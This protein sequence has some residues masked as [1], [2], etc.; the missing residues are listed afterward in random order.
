MRGLCKSC[1]AAIWWAR[2]TKGKPIPLDPQPVV[3]GN[4][5][6]N[7]GI[8]RYVTPDQNAVTQRFVSHFATCKNAEQHR[9]APRG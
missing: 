8:A 7:G 5:E 4:I 1:Q 6:V 3:G 2:T 9:K